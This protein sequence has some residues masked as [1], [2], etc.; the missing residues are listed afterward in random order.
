MVGTRS[1]RSCAQGCQR[2][3]AVKAP[4]QRKTN[5]GAQAKISQVIKTGAQAQPR[6]RPGGKTGKRAPENGRA[7]TDEC[8]HPVAQDLDMQQPGAE[9]ISKRKRA[10]GRYKPGQRKGSWAENSEKLQKHQAQKQNADPPRRKRK[11]SHSGRYKRGDRKGSWAVNMHK[12][13]H[14]GSATAAASEPL[15]SE[16]L[17]P[18][19]HAWMM[20]P[21]TE[22][23]PREPD[24]PREPDGPREPEGMRMPADDPHSSE[25]RGPG[26]PVEMKTPRWDPEPRS[27]SLPSPRT[28]ACLAK[29]PKLPKSWA[30]H[31]Y[32]LDVRSRAPCVSRFR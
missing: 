21:V 19:Q 14:G 22:L 3:Q 24:D 20:A 7:S 10:S 25:A 28:K 1:S 18:G 16:P 12:L 11:P 31:P 4:T 30:V 23:L 9:G 32:T 26:Q 5:G 15:P 13:G 2:G 27:P 6:Q 8:K 17:G 29:V